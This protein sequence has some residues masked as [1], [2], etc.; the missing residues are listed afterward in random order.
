[1]QRPTFWLLLYPWVLAYLA[2]YFLRGGSGMDGLLS[3]CRD[4]LWAP[5]TQAAYR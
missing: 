4:I 2:A 3:S 1:M 5:I